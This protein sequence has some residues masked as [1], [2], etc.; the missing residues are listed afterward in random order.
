MASLIMFYRDCIIDKN[1]RIG[2]NVVIANS[3]V[4]FFK[5]KVDDVVGGSRV[6][7]NYPLTTIT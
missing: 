2:K 3:E 5:L 4:C 7:T 6:K 1:A